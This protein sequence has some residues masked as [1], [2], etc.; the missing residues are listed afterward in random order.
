MRISLGIMMSLIAFFS[1]TLAAL[2]PK[3]QRHSSTQSP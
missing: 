1:T 3:L 2:V